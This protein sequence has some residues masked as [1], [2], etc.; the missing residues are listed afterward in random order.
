ML[1]DEVRFVNVQSVITD[2]DTS[3]YESQL[4]GKTFRPATLLLRAFGIVDMMNAIEQL[5]T[6][7]FFC[8]TI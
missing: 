5:R 8:N 1:D 2:L 7:F 3:G 6:I 4:S